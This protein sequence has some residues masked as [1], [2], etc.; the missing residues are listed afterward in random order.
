VTL[1]S[2]AMT[3]LGLPII[4]LTAAA[5]A[6]GVAWQTNFLGIQQ[7][8]Q[9]AFAILKPSFD[10]LMKQVEKLLPALQKLWDTISPYL[11]PVLKF[12]GEVI[13]AVVVV[14][15]KA[16]IESVT[17]TITI[18]NALI[19][20]TT[21]TVKW[22][23]EL[24]DRYGGDIKAIFDGLIKYFGSYIDLVVGIFTGDG[25]KIKT[26][27]NSMFEGLKETVEGI[28]NGIIKI[29]QD[30]INK[31][32][33]LVTAAQNAAGTVGTYL[34][35][36]A[37][38]GSSTEQ[39]NTAKKTAFDNIKNSPDYEQQ[40]ARFYSLSQDEQDQIK[41]NMIKYLGAFPYANGGIV[42]GN[43]YTG[44]RVP[45][46]VNSGEMILNQAQQGRLFAMANGGNTNNSRQVTINQNNNIQGQVGLQSANKE[47]AFLVTN[48]I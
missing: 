32:Q 1:L 7:S 28:F 15:L 34:T 21:E 38:T 12:L 13:W 35:G 30:T 19:D 44:D 37:V 47:L 23:K 26:A 6:L 29:I 8:T 45:A 5:I 17:N 20:K 41:K 9:T 46:F 22:L 10:T 3:V 25:D 42:G 39:Q 18:Y 14:A 24:W 48:N 40:K 43:S 11:I 36:G 2:A 33:E 16:L 4:A 31:I 27:F